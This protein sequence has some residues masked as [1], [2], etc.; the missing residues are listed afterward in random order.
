MIAGQL[1]DEE[2][3]PLLTVLQPMLEGRHLIVTKVAN[4]HFRSIVEKIGSAE[5]KKRTDDFMKNVR[6][7]EDIDWA[8]E[9]HCPLFKCVQKFN[10]LSHLSSS[11]TLKPFPLEVF[12]LGDTI[13]CMVT[14]TSNQSIVRAVREQNIF[15]RVFIHSPRALLTNK[16][17]N[18]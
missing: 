10:R 3:E 6:V 18:I 4:A 14:V 8:E 12:G 1:R 9:L 17:E 13:P 11:N 7:F 2:Q 16:F 5:E 15:L